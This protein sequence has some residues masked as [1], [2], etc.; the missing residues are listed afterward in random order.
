MIEDE[1]IIQAWNRRRQERHARTRAMEEVLHLYEG[2]I[3]VPLTEID[4]VDRP[5]VMNMTLQGI[6]GTAQRFASTMPTVYFPHDRD[7]ATQR[8]LSRDRRDAVLGWWEASRMN[9]S[10][11]TRGRWYAGYAA[12]TTYICPDYKLGI[13][14]W[15]PRD[16]LCSFPSGQDFETEDCIF[17]FRR[18]LG[19]CED[20]YPDAGIRAKLDLREAGKDHPVTVLQYVDADELIMLAVAGAPYQT[21]P[22]RDG[23]VRL[24][25]V[26]NRAGICP[27]VAFGRPGL[28]SSV[29]P[30]DGMTGMYM[31]Q[32][33]LTALELI[34]VRKDIF[35]DQW[36]VGG[37]NA[38][39]LRPADGLRG[40]VGIVQDG[41]ITSTSKPPGYMTN[42]TID[43][44]ERGQRAQIGMPVEWQGESGS[45][46]RTG[47]RGDQIMSQVT[48]FALQEAHQLFAEA[49]AAENRVAVAIDK[50]WFSG[51]KTVYMGGGK[52]SVT[53]DSSLWSTDR[54]KVTY[55]APG[56]DVN[57]LVIGLAQRVGTGTMS[58]KTAMEMDPLVDDPEREADAVTAE[59]L[60]AAMLASI[61]Q[62]ASTGELPPMDVARIAQL[63]RTDRK[64]LAEAI[65]QA[66]REAQERQA[67]VAEE[68]NAPEV[69]PGLSMPGMGAEA[70]S[71]I[72]EP[73]QG[74]RN[75]S[76]LMANLGMPQMVARRA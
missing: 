28:G 66:Q 36:V 63:V 37:P 16:P 75:L 27:V 35:Q 46:I 45:N 3:V 30:F 55:S 76:S 12:N 50:A 71:P 34:A 69:M 65:M 7:N 49:L 74:T 6:D 59:S 70:M 62:L 21:E 19:W 15:E 53:Y 22:E 43:R 56:A 9:I 8:R 68:P 52:R 23:H 72:P 42:V 26:D 47:K 54:N 31:Q 44:L 17:S 41:N 39:V 29:S 40:I 14:R 51:P 61:T 58:K 13:P 24:S 10:L 73:P 57:S 38:N 5:A 20:H 2:N 64:E 18:T 1:Q 60:E 33:L 25:R 32:A 48:D 11:Y 67:S 4:K